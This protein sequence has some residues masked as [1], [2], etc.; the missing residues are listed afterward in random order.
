[1]IKSVL[2]VF[3]YYFNNEEEILRKIFSIDSILN[4]ELYKYLDYFASDIYKYKRPGIKNML[5]DTLEK[6]L[7]ISIIEGDEKKI[8]AIHNISNKMGLRTGTKSARCIEPDFLM[9]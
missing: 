6:N 8:N 2:A 4:Y 7:I 1:M 3:D 5:N 9:L